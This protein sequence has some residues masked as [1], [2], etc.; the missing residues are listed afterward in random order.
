MIA[1]HYVRHSK[2][3]AGLAWAFMLALPLLLSGC[4]RSANQSGSAAPVLKPKEA[5]SQLQQVFVTADPEV[6]STATAATKALQTADYEQAIES[7]QTIKARGN[8]TFEQGIAVQNSMIALESRLI[9][10]AESGDA[11][12]KRAYELL[13]RVRKN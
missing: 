3:I 7:L 8:L 13:K 6:K 4:S 5:A 9:S 2:Q 10:A 1:R 11:N 12:A